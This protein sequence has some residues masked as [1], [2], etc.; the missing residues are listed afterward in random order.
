MQTEIYTEMKVTL[1]FSVVNLK[2][3]KRTLQKL[4]Q[5]YITKEDF[6]REQTDDTRQISLI[7]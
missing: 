6:F 4:K 3:V 1:R 5:D 7:K 2:T